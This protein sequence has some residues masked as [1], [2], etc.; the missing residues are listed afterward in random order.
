MFSCVITLFPC[1]L[2]LFRVF[3]NEKCENVLLVVTC[4]TRFFDMCFSINFHAKTH[5]AHIDVF[6]KQRIYAVA[7]TSTFSKE[8]DTFVTEHI[9]VS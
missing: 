8:I 3:L 1:V 4:G 6:I 7:H 9:H 2:T 5:G